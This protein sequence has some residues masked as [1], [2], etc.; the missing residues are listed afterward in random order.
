[1]HLNDYTSER[2]NALIG[3][4]HVYHSSAAP[5]V[6]VSLGC[7]L[8]RRNIVVAPSQYASPA[9]LSFLCAHTGGPYT[10][11]ELCGEH[12]PAQARCEAP[13]LTL[14]ILWPRQSLPCSSF[15]YCGKLIF[16]EQCVEQRC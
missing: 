12:W 15:A 1:M 6:S 11:T 4:S 16:P 9:R 5:S 14:F 2:R 10:L 8:Y 3:S 13:A 7:S